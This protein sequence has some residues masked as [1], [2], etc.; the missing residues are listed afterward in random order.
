MTKMKHCARKC[1][2]YTAF[3][4]FRIRQKL[5]S[6]CACLPRQLSSD[7]VFTPPALANRMLDLLPQSLW[8]DP[9]ARFLDPACKSGVFLREIAKRLGKGLEQTIPDRQE[10]INHIMKNQLFGIAITKLTAL[11][12]RRTLYCIQTRQRQIFGVHRF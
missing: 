6:R 10:R 4:Q 1:Y 9:Q 8:S 2:P 3:I 12:A 7:E 5:Q 11:M